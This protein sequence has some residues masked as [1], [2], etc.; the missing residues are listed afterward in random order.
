[1]SKLNSI[2]QIVKTVITTQ[3]KHLIGQKAHN[4]FKLEET[5]LDTLAQ[6]QVNQTSTVTSLQKTMEPN[7]FSAKLKFKLG[8]APIMTGLYQM[9]NQF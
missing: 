6:S 8:L 9:K 5:K 2:N 1:M 3:I 4:D 7:Y